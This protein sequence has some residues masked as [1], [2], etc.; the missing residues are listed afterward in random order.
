MTRA[1]AIH[2]GVLRL[3]LHVPG[4]RTLKDGRQAV[5]SLRDRLRHRFD[6]SVHEI[7]PSERATRRVLIVTT[8]GHDARLIRSILDRVRGA[9]ESSG[10]VLLA[11][12]DVDVFPWQPRDRDWI[13][14]DP[15]GSGDG[16]GGDGD[17]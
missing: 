9:A 4:A 5:V 14:L 10:Q 8:A 1:D 3:V 17:G 7:E 2:I 11:E 13:P 15:S 16:D 6:V 12:V